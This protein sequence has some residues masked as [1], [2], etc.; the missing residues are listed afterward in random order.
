MLCPAVSLPPS[1]AIT[2]GTGTA[3]SA[4]SAASGRVEQ[5]D[6][7]VFQ[8]FNGPGLH[9][10]TTPFESVAARRFSPPLLTRT[11]FHPGPV[12]DEFAERT[13]VDFSGE[14]WPGDASV[15]PRPA[16]TLQ[17]LR[18]LPASHRADAIRSLRGHVA[19]TELY[20]VDGSE[21]ED[22]PFTV[23][24]S[25][26]GIREESPPAGGEPRISHSLETA[27][28]IALASKEHRTI[29]VTC[30]RSRA[31]AMSYSLKPSHPAKARLRLTGNPEQPARTLTC[32]P[33]V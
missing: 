16:G 3:Q 20:A 29:L 6:T 4:S 25:H 5:L 17:L 32:M 31:P 14:Y 12:G 27:P 28:G 1:T 9:G 2:T 11:W 19:R 30:Q 13:E 7:E 18:S 8:E 26:Y 24:E 23:T 22:R 10:T 15:L 21:R 33:L